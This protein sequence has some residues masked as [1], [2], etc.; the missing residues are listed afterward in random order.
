MESFYSDLAAWLV[1]VV[2]IAASVCC[3]VVVLVLIVL[4]RYVDGSE[5]R[6][7]RRI[8]DLVGSVCCDWDSLAWDVGDR[9]GVVY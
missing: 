8:V 7:V 1:V 6:Q 4:I 3:W 9:G 5:T 2:N